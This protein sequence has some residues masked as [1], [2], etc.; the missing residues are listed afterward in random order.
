MIN[1]LDDIKTLEKHAID[2][3]NSSTPYGYTA[4]AVH[5]G[6][7]IIAKA[8]RGWLYEMIAEH[9]FPKAH[10]SK[11]DSSYTFLTEHIGTKSVYF[12]GMVKEIASDLET[13]Y[14]N[15]ILQ[16]LMDG[17][18]RSI[19]RNFRFLQT[20]G[21]RGKMEIEEVMNFLRTKLARE[22]VPKMPLRVLSTPE[23]YKKLSP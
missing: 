15:A 9:Y 20:L 22:H 2:A 4:R 6:S 16:A 7:S 12:D 10:F 1:D 11:R 3:I 17:E 14:V 5:F 13:F 19:E 18:N 8:T 21:Y 23:Y